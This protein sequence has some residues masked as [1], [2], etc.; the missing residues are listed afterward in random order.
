MQR[1][2]IWILRAFKT[3]PV[4]GIKAIAGIIPIRLHLQKLMS[5]SQLCSLALLFSHLVQTLM[6]DPSNLPTQQHPN[7]LNTLT[8]CQRSLIK[9]HLVDSNN[10]LY[11][12]FPS[13][14]PLH[15][16]LFPG[17][18]IIDNFPEQFSFNLSNKEKS[19]KIHFQQ[20]DN[21]VL[22]L[23]SSLSMAIIVMDASIKNDIATSILHV[24]LANHPMTK[25]VHHVAFVISTKAELSIIRCGIN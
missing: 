6:D 20:L 25:T 24:H 22:E 3:S 11:G 2:T 21:I 1:A 12:I 9:G 23:S 18:R 16:E 8:S 10:K 7:L 15:L 13:F 17:F 5:R 14:S 4:E 19:D